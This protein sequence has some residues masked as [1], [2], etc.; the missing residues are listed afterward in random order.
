M[1]S[2]KAWHSSESNSNILNSWKVWELYQQKKTHSEFS[3]LTRDLKLNG[4]LI[5]L[6][7]CLKQ[8]NPATHFW[9][10]T[11]QLWITDVKDDAWCCQMAHYIVLLSVSTEYSLSLHCI[12]CLFISYNREPHCGLTIP[13]IIQIT[14]PKEAKRLSEEWI[15]SHLKVWKDKMTL[16]LKARGNTGRDLSLHFSFNIIHHRIS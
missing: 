6:P 16:I 2:N 8:N 12:R 5:V 1:L 4:S 9:S 13:I 15:S 14:E 7:C 11:H 3:Y 10:M